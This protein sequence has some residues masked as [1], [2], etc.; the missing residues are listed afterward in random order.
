[1]A[2]GEHGDGSGAERSAMAGE[3][4]AAREAR[5]GDE[6]GLPEFAV[7]GSKLIYGT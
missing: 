6:A 3:I 7:L 1:M 2:A 5:D 4:D